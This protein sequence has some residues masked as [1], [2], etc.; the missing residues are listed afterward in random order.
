MHAPARAKMSDMASGDQVDEYT[1]KTRDWLDDRFRTTD[2]RGVYVAHQPIYGFRRGPYDRGAVPRYVRSHRIL[3]ALAQIEFASLLD[4]G[5]AEGYHSH[6]VRHFF[7]SVTVRHSDL[8]AEACRRAREIFGLESE[9]AD[10]H[11]LPFPD[12]AFD[13]VLCSESIEHVTDP[14]QAIKELLR[15]A[16]R[17]LVVT[18]P[19]EPE[20]TVAQNREHHDDHAHLHTFDLNSFK[21]LESDGYV[22]DSSPLV[23]PI[24]RVLGG[25][26]DGARRPPTAGLRGVMVRAFNIASPVVAALAPDRM[27]ARIVEKDRR[28][29]EGRYGYEATLHVISRANSTKSVARAAPGAFEIMNVAVPEHRLM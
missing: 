15:V 12:G 29:A 7:P 1:R 3:S 17:A 11:H 18:V 13:V 14:D 2:S 5:G 26:I 8:S 16:A 9:Q 10:V 19:H 20:E 23:S 25:L 27:A 6:L 4:V 22:V 21:H 28:R 24:S